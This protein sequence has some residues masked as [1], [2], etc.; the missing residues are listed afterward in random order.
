MKSIPNELFFKEIENIISAGNEVELRVKGISML[1]YLRSNIDI[2]ILS[3]LKIRE[4]KKGQIVLF[5]YKGKHLLHRIIKINGEE[6]VIQGD[7]NFG[8]EEARISD[9]IGVVTAVIRS[10]GKKVSVERFQ[11]Q[12]Y[13]KIWIALRPARRYLLWGIKNF[14]QG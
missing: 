14:R 7:G 8:R 5:R 4:L 13:W 11:D 2:V 3:P 6:L 9:I 10:N 12:I 1:P